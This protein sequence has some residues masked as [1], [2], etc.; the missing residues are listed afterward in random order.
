MDRI[1]PFWNIIKEYWKKA[2]MTQIVILLASV[3]LLAFLAFFAYYAK[4]ANVGQLKKGLEQATIIYDKDGD[5][6]SKISAN[7]SEGVSIKKMPEDLQNAIVAIE[8]HRFYK[9]HG[10]DII[11]TMS[12]L[13]KDIK[14]GGAAAG[15][16]TITQQLTKN[17]LLSPERTLKRKIQ[18]LFLAIEIEKHYT[19][20]EILEMYLN[21]VY[22]GEGAW[23]V[24]KAANKYFGK[25]IQDLDLSE[26]ATLAGLVNSPSALDPY[27]HYDRAIQ[28]RNVV[29]S[30]MKQYGMI[31]EAEYKAAKSEKLVLKDKKTDALKG[32]YPYYVDAVLDEAIN[33]Y[34]LTQEEILTRGYKIYTE[35]DQNIQSSLENVY[36]QNSLFPAGKSDQM[37]QSGAILVDPKT[38]GVRGLVGGRGEKVFR[39]FNRAT[40][41]KRQPGS[42]MKPITVYTPALEEGYTP[43]S[44]L[45][46]KEMTFRGGYAPK[47]YNNQYL[48]E[49]P[50]YEAVEKSL[51][52]P[53]VWLLNKIGVEK[54]YESAKKFGI[55]LTKGDKQLGIALGNI[56]NGVSPEEI[57]QAY[58]TFPNNGNR[59][60]VHIIK[61]IVSPTGQVIVEHK[62]KQ[63]RV[64]SKKV[65]QEM[66]SML[67]NV[68]ESGTGKGVSV[69]G[70]K[71]A[72]KTGSTQLPFSG[73]E[74]TMD[75]WFAGY[76]PN[77]VGVVWMG[78]DK[79][80][81][82]HYLYGLSEQGIVP[83]FNAVMNA[84]LKYT[85][86][87]DFGVESINEQKKN[88][89]PLKEKLQNIDETIKEQADKLKETIEENKGFWKDAADKI[90]E[91]LKGIL[92]Q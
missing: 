59:S 89:S 2:H 27:H 72:G 26:S 83:V 42:I 23:G 82:N 78:Y 69:P 41:L 51:N 44:M 6:A 36:Q 38:G 24:Q 77:L 34:G 91:Q 28:R 31:T 43:D 8:D 25:D 9:H 16:S 35:M 15:G 18:E 67:L 10:F 66:T 61:K 71:I 54:G 68:V 32:K 29:L 40:Q 65:S 33:Q 5:V 47:N 30:V 17:A 56:Q 86:P 39:G 73:A 11:G 58:T 81:R 50:M 46:D 92:G 20:K 22:F 70:Y 3:S 55:P 64:T 84:T 80:N 7:R 63:E 75:Q 87:G 12:A 37:I 45:K 14:A 4:S 76:T 13:L 53:A 48:G 85:K 19:K 1:K 57:A 79:T 88:G 60:D 90:K 21:Q 62:D 52:L 74:G 49:V